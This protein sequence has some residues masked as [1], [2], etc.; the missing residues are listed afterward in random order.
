MPLLGRGRY[1]SVGT[2]LL[3]T[4]YALMKLRH[5]LYHMK[6]GVAFYVIGSYKT[7]SHQSGIK[8]QNATTSF[9]YLTPKR[10]TD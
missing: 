6:D 7:R 10:T 9:F 3:E 5:V 2:P 4:S 8:V 1:R